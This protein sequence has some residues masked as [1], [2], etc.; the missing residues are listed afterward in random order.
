MEGISVSSKEQIASVE[1]ISATANELGTPA[2]EL[3]NKIG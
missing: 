3:K 2:D 1:V